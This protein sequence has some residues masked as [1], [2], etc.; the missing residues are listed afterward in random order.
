MQGILYI[1]HGSRVPE[2]TAEASAC[3]KDVMDHVGMPLQEICFLELAEPT[4]EQGMANLVSQGAT[5]IAIVPVLL[6]SAGHYYKDIPEDIQE[7]KKSYP[8]ITFTYGEPLGV[9][10]R[11]TDVLVDRLKETAVIP[12]PDARIL[13][14]GRGSKNQQTKRDIEQIKYHLK[15]KAGIQT[16]IG[17]LAASE[18]PFEESLQSLLTDGSQQIFIIPYLWFTGILMR[19]LEARTQELQEQ[20]FNVYL[21]RQLGSHQL[22]QEAL[23][24]RVFESIES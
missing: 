20:G 24:E 17:F 3:I 14:V 19:Q 8:D 23:R 9:Q 6:L 2:A 11:L 5:R 12:G 15:K 4:I 16:E 13:L 21:C 22:M 7:A 1:S 18:P 10:E